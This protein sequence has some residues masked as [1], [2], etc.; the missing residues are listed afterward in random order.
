MLFRSGVGQLK[1]LT[2]DPGTKTIILCADNDGMSTNTKNAVL[3]ALQRWQE[4][5]YQ[6]K[7]AM[8]FDHDITKKIDFN[9][10]LNQHGEKA[11]NQSVSKAIDIGDLSS[12]SNKSSPLAKDFI[13]VQSKQQIN[14]TEFSQKD[15]LVVSK[16][17]E[18]LN[19][20]LL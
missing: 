14:F 11:V 10:L 17:Q 15:R 8:P 18:S 1:N 4:Q 2:I 12:F 3:D 16:N 13:K 20:L 19:E 6:V 9:D 7:L 5:G